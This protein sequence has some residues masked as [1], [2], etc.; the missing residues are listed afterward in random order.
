MFFRVKLKFNVSVITIRNQR[1]VEF[2]EL[3]R[4]RWKRSWVSRCVLLWR[5]T[6]YLTLGRFRGSISSIMWAEFLCRCFFF[7]IPAIYMPAYTNFHHFCGSAPAVIRFLL[8]RLS[9]STNVG[10]L[11]VRHLRWMMY[12]VCSVQFGGTVIIGPIISL[13]SL[14]LETPKNCKFS[15]P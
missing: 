1:G 5:L 8:P 2:N 13:L 9:R 15:N 10:L 12:L 3:V 11:M 4:V 14:H 7:D 6:M